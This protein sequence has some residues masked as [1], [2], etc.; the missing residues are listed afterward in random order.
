MKNILDYGLWDVKVYQ[1]QGLFQVRDGSLH[2]YPCKWSNMRS[3]LAISI[4]SKIVEVKLLGG[5]TPS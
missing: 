1:E 5:C 4:L 3:D 2:H